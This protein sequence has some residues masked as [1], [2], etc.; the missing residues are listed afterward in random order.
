M[1]GELEPY[2]VI[3]NEEAAADHINYWGLWEKHFPNLDIMDVECFQSHGA[4]IR[5]QSS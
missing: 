4:V 1:L 5:T 2:F 3:S